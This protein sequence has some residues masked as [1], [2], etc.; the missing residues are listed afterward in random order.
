M[1]PSIFS[2]AWWDLCMCWENVYSD[3]LLTKKRLL[4]ECCFWVVKV[5]YI[6]WVFQVTYMTWKCFLT[7]ERLTHCWL[8]LLKKSITVWCN[9]IS[10]LPHLS[11]F[12]I[13]LPRNYPNYRQIHVMKLSPHFLLRSCSF[14]IVC[15]WTCYAAEVDIELVINPASHLVLPHLVYAVFGLEPGFGPAEQAFCQMIYIFRPCV[16]DLIDF[17]VVSVVCYLLRI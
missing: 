9:I 16:F 5:L 12:G 4:G 6:C 17:K 10:P 7:S 1:M 8:F 13:T 11:A 14:S 15:P 2:C 3:S